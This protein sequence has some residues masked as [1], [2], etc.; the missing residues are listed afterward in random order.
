MIMRT[1]YLHIFGTSIPK[2]RTF[3]ILGLYRQN[4]D[5]L[6][7]SGVLCNLHNTTLAIF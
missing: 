5:A 6:L 3:F 4:R 2:I 1:F 7:F